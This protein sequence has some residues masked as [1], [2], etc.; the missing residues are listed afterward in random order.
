MST[1]RYTA[2][3]GGKSCTAITTD[4]GRTFTVLLHQDPG[5]GPMILTRIYR[6]EVNLL[7]EIVDEPA[8]EEPSASDLLHPLAAAV[9]L[10]RLHPAPAVRAKLAE[11][12]T[13]VAV[14]LA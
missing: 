10:G 7:A 1:S 6:S 14:D 4:D 13:R 8:D 5:Y 2:T 9:R 3:Y 11:L 12:R